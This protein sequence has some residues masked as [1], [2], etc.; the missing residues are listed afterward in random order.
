MADT[1]QP[2]AEKAPEATTAAETEVPAEKPAAPE[3]TASAPQKAADAQASTDEATTTPE[4]APQTSSAAVATDEKTALDKETGVS[5]TDDPATADSSASSVVAAAADDDKKDGEE[6]AIKDASTSAPATA[7]AATTTAEPATAKAKTPLDEFDAKL[8]AL[9]KEV[10]HD[11]MWG[12]TLVSPASSHVPT[13]IVLQKFLNA[14]DGDLAKAVDQFKGALAFRKAKKPLDLVNKTFSAHK[15]ADLGAVTVYPAKDGAGVPEVF[16]WNLYGNVKGKMD[17][18]FVPLDEYVQQTNFECFTVKV[19]PPFADARTHA[20]TYTRQVHELP[21]RPA[22]TRHPAI[23]LVL[24]HG[25]HHG[26]KGPVQDH[27]GARLQEHL[28]PAPEP[29]R[30]GR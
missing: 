22:R 2:T 20:R 29:K 27:P 24:G 6:K 5:K 8:P 21:Y 25:D 28:L 3:T 13:A 9:L 23:K 14:N 10:G 11:E 26:R 19:D 17:E 15:F 30:Q 12:V 16:T 7:A 18:V 1:N 4:A